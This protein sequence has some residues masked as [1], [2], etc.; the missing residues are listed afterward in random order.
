MTLA[1]PSLPAAK[2]LNPPPGRTSPQPQK[3]TRVILVPAAIPL[4]RSMTLIRLHR[5]TRSLASASTCPIRT[6]MTTMTS[7]SNGSSS[8][9]AEAESTAEAEV[10]TEVTKGQIPWPARDE[11]GSPGP[12]KGQDTKSTTE[13]LPLTWEPRDKVR[14]LSLFRFSFLYFDLYTNAKTHSGERLHLFPPSIRGVAVLFVTA[15]LLLSPQ[16]ANAINYVQVQRR[17]KKAFSPL[18]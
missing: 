18:L 17:E 4:R 12:R 3:V 1:A 6:R 15:T 16:S 7:L 5:S 8:T 9:V 11:K 2:P 14:K 10:T 13:N